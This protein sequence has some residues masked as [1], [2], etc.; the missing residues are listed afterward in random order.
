MN[1]TTICFMEPGT[2]MWVTRNGSTRFHVSTER[3]EIAPEA[4]RA[5]TLDESE[6]EYKGFTVRVYTAHIG[7][8]HT[9]EAVD[10]NRCKRCNG[11]G[12]LS[13]YKHVQN[14][15]CFGCGGTGV[16]GMLPAHAF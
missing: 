7:R 9:A 15:V 8:T 12:S 13:A 6:F 16:K 14:G 11:R 1:R 2:E 4:I 10:P 3:I 5:V